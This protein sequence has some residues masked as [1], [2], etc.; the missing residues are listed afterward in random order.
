M[1]K[2]NRG[3]V[4]LKI[5]YNMKKEKNRVLPYLIFIFIATLF[6]S[7]GYAAINAISLDIGGTVTASAQENVFITNVE[8]V[9]NVDADVSNSEILNFIQTTMNSKITLSSTNPNSSITYRVTLHNNSNVSYYFD[10]VKYDSSF[11]DNQDI[12]FN[13]S[14]SRLDEIQSNGSLTFTITFSYKDNV[15]ANEHI[16]NSYLN[17]AFLR[18]YDITYLLYDNLS[19]VESYL[20]GENVNALLE[21]T[22]NGFTFNG[23]YDENNNLVTSINSISSNIQLHADW[24]EDIIVGN[25][26]KGDTIIYNP[27]ASSENSSGSWYSEGVLGYSAND[28]SYY[29]S[30]DYVGMTPVNTTFTQ[31]NLEWKIWD[32]NDN[33]VR[34]VSDTPTTQRLSIYKAKGY[35]NGLFFLNDICSKLYAGDAVGITAKNLT[36][37]D[38]E[39]KMILHYAQENPNETGYV[40]NDG[41]PIWSEDNIKNIV[42]ISTY[43]TTSTL[44]TGTIR[45]IP[46]VLSN[47]ISNRTTASQT[48][49]ISLSDIDLE[50]DYSTA[51]VATPPMNSTYWTG[52][53][54]TAGGTKRP[55]TAKKSYYQVSTDVSNY[56]DNIDYD[57]IFNKNSYWLSSRSTNTSSSKFT[58]YIRLISQ[59]NTITQYQMD[60]TGSKD[61]SYGTITIG[62][63]GYSLRLRPIV[64]IDRD[65]Y[66]LV[67]TS[68]DTYRIVAK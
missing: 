23:W 9:S 15:V 48:M 39:E 16:L 35:N 60:D 32:I 46:M 4:A 5:N 27:V 54:Y 65:K 37:R 43:G 40:D 12:V 19:E 18:R 17:F 44:A 67:E 47:N 57:M 56:F 53:D 28:H 45:Y 26:K 34:L 14:L 64:T 8:Y 42:N 55:I 11:Y 6:M 61:G 52:G 59:N 10:E 31:E 50:E 13:T 21:P 49:N 30:S 3:G 29:V 41:N 62:D 1:F 2:T 33:E 20:E 63:D 58:F 38:I 25:P 51:T 22:R 68:D 7:I 36:Y 66:D 24:E